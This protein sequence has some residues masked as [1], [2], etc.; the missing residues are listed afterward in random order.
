MV[1][2]EEKVSRRHPSWCNMI[3]DR[4]MIIHPPKATLIGD[5]LLISS[6]I[7]SHRFGSRTSN[8]LWFRFPAFSQPSGES[9]PFVVALLL[10]AM[11][12]GEDIEVRGTELAGQKAIRPVR[13]QVLFAKRGTEYDAVPAR[14]ARGRFVGAE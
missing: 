12:N 6:R 14:G 2:Q 9:D 10:L 4:T 7:E 8:N 13:E 1:D 5:D 3:R 11:Q